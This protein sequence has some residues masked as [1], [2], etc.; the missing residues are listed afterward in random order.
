MIYIEVG[1][2]YFFI[3]GI[4]ENKILMIANPKSGG[5][6][7]ID[8]LPQAEKIF[9]ELGCFPEIRISSKAG[10]ALTISRLAAAAGYKK[11]VAVGGDG[12]VNE[13]ASG[14]IGSKSVFGVIPAGRGNGFYRSL[15]CQNDLEQQCR[16]VT[17]GKIRYLDVGIAQEKMFFNTLG[18]GFD[19]EIANYY[20]SNPNSDNSRWLATFSALKQM[21]RFKIDLRF[22]N[23]RYS[24]SL[25]S[26]TVNIGRV[27]GNGLSLAPAALPDDGKLDIC[28]VPDSKPYR[29]MTLV[30]YASKRNDRMFRMF[31]MFRCRRLEIVCKTPLLAHIDGEKLENDGK[32]TI[33]VFSGILPTAVEQDGKYDR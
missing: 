8:L 2:N 11:I 20:A 4:S 22:D 5:G 12:T 27:S 32:I 28:V 23:Y 3:M 9:K 29:L 13:V 10:E 14:I 6:K 1:S 24:E 31:K 7:A 16:I 18:I 33:N 19:A 26:L 21:H 30:W 15:C 25:S 17:S